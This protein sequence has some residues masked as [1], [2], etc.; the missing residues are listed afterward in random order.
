MFHTRVVVTE[1]RR[2]L[3]VNGLK[4]SGN[5]AV[6]SWIRAHGEFLF[7]N[8][9]IPAAP[10]LD[11]RASIPDAAD[12]SIWT[13]RHVSP[14]LAWAPPLARR[15]LRGKSVIVS[16]ED[17]D[18]TIAPFTNGPT[19]TRNVLIL[20]QPRNLFAS[21]VRKASLKRK[22]PAYKTDPESMK[23]VVGLWKQHAREFLGRT[24]ILKDKICILYDRWFTDE[25]YRRQISASLDLDFTDDGFR[26]VSPIGGGSS[27]DG[28]TL[29]GSS[30]AMAVLS[31]DE[32]LNEGELA[33]VQAVLAD[34]ELQELAQAIDESR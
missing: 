33:L 6:I 22:N 1:V 20:R 31:R 27:F 21:R 5:H 23:R 16:F 32:C 30:S 12:F 3:L 7:F 4:R 10:I 34:G 13:T 9:A 29:D 11:G 19:D 17:L 18:L 14:W 15:R 28:T 2:L 24:C 25:P 8:N 26:H